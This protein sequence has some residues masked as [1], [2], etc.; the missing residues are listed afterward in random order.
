MKSNHSKAGL[1]Q[2]SFK[3][4]VAVRR[5]L[6]V[7]IIVFAAL[8]SAELVHAQGVL[9]TVTTTGDGDDALVGDGLCADS[10][11]DCTLRAAIHEANFDGGDDGI[12]FDLSVTDPNYDGTKWTIPLTM[13]LPTITDSVAITGPGADKLT[14]LRDSIELF[15]IFD[16][17]APTVSFSA[18]TIAGG[19]SSAG[20]GGIQVSGTQTVNVN[21]CTIFGNAG[22]GVR[23]VSPG[24]TANLTDCIVSGNSSGGI[25]ANVGTLTI[26]NSIFTGNSGGGL[27][28][29]EVSSILLTLSTFTDNTAGSGGGLVITSVMDPGAILN[30]IN[31][32][33]SGNHADGGTLALGGGIS[34]VTFSPLNITDCMF[35][36]NDTSG[37]GGG[38]VSVGPLVIS[39]CTISGNSA[40]GSGGGITAFSSLTLTLSTLSD[41]T[42]A[43]DEGGGL[44]F[45]PIESLRLASVA[46]CTLNGNSA[47]S[48]GGIAAE[49]PLSLTSSTITA[50]TATTGNGGGIFGGPSATVVTLTNSTIAANVAPSAGAIGGGIRNET[51]QPIFVKSCIVALNTS[52]SGPD[53]SGNFTS[54][55]TGT[56]EGFNL[57]G[58]TDG[59]TGFTAATDRTGTIAA[60]LD[61]KLDPSGLQ[62]HGGPTQTIA[63]LVGSP[64]IDQATSDGLTGPL[65]TD[66]RGVGFPRTFDQAEIP[67]ATG[68]DGT[69]I[70]AFELETT[71]S[72]FAN[73][74]TR[75]RVETG[76]NVLIGG[77]IITGTDVK[78]VLLRAIGPSLPLTGFL[79]DP[80]LELHDEDGKVIAANDNWQ[81]SLN[82]QEIIDTGIAPAND[83]ESALLVALDPGA[84]TAIIRGAN[85]GSGIGLVEAYDLDQTVD[86]KLAN[87]STRGLVQTG[88]DVMIGGFIILGTEPSDVL[89]RAIGPSLPLTGT[90]VDPM[91]ELHDKDGVT[92]ASNDDW[93]SDQEADIMA[94]GLPPTDDAESAILMTL[95]PDAYT[96][97][98][99]GKDNTTGV[100]LVEAYQLD[101]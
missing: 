57:I 41:N 25:Y 70:G 74:S 53:V 37:S 91:L 49:G 14:V 33:V 15:G 88:D 101:K 47:T 46:N 99:R 98:V 93:R 68:G 79:A 66:Q 90:L 36:G 16:V 89:L 51:G 6:I 23:I 54:S 50:N 2:R 27:F 1:A 26:T 55:A 12:E 30:V 19:N 92:I 60:P 40:V 5:W 75:E 45:S 9:F 21:N 76:D 34:A 62:D 43:G 100:A 58:K 31:C 52:E 39:S 73:I 97:I 83:L 8:S 38:I 95:T 13:A 78:K 32:T 29:S 72:T 59:S 86:S 24:S 63:L 87:I 94:T 35:S 7:A 61:P 82:K 65:T 18:L 4:Q 28:A 3:S 42:A 71:P 56:S 17:T 48:G 81:L 77:F 80:T 22:D 85:G 11:G 67:N 10:N 44:F 20:G 96:A 69:D 84:Y 64:A